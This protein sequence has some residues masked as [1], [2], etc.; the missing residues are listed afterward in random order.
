MIIGIFIIASIYFH[1]IKKNQV[2]AII[3]LIIAGFFLRIL[4][5]FIDPF[6]Q[7]W[8]ERFHAL[9]AKN[10]IT[11][12]FQPMLRID[13]IMP[14]KMEDWCCN[15]IWVH[16]QPLF[17]WQMAISMKLFGINEIAIR[18]PSVIMGSISIFFIYDIGKNWIKHIDVA[19]LAALFFTVSYYQLELTSGRFPLDQNDVA[20]AFYVTASIWA[21]VKYLSSEEKLKWSLIIGTFV[22]CS[23]LVKWLT[24]LLIFGGWGLYLLLE[25]RNSFDL[26]QWRYLM[27]A[28]LMSMMI[29]VPWQ[30]YIANAFPIETSLMHQSNR[31]HIFEDLGHPGSIW[32]H[33]NHMRTAYGQFLLLFI[34][35]GFY[36]ILKAKEINKNLSI[37]F[38]SM[39]LVIYFFFSIIVKT[40]M[41]AFAFPVNS[42]IWIILAA[43]VV[44]SLKKIPMI[45]NIYWTFISVILLSFYTLK[46]WQISK[47][48]SKSNVE[49]NN[50]IENTIIYKELNF[51]DK[52]KNRVVLNCK[53]F[54]DVELM[55]YKDVNAYH[56]YPKKDI[57]DSL[58]DNGYKFAAFKNHN[59]QLLPEYIYNQ[60]NIIIIDKLIK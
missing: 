14:Y 18:I 33:L 17:L 37:A 51:E 57:L 19:Y 41:P 10:L 15:H 38:I 5:A 45:N 27:T 2:K 22:G 23:I 39:I 55:F 20:F 35:I 21:Y 26:K 44:T 47:H 53:S 13:P 25:S 29:F 1:F 59:N 48:R 36:E 28:A 24:G 6:L 34:P 50:K 7:D 3:F 8:D 46:P 32:F 9:V 42:L 56:W 58:I 4:F 11:N 16:K 60:E 43:G 12:P 40:K 49:R 54:E 52:L 30:L 31:D